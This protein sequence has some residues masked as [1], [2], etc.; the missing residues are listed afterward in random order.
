MKILRYAGRT[1][2]AL[3]YALAPLLA[4]GSVAGAVLAVC[5]S[6]GSASAL[7][8]ALSRCARG[9]VAR[10]RWLFVIH[11]W[12]RHLLGA[13]PALADEDDAVGSATLFGKPFFPLGLRDRVQRVAEGKRCGRGEDS[14]WRTARAF[15]RQ[16]RMRAQL[17]SPA[18]TVVALA[19]E[20]QFFSHPCFVGPNSP[21]ERCLFWSFVSMIERHCWSAAVDLVSFMPTLEA[22]WKNPAQLGLLLGL[23]KVGS[24]V[25][26]VAP[27]EL[28]GEEAVETLIIGASAECNCREELIWDVVGPNQVLVGTT[29][30][31]TDATLIRVGTALIVPS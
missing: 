22:W 14:A 10:G 17:G 27:G 30:S 20:T 6:S 12:I 8:E 9:F 7:V 31:D 25:Q 1:P 24:A 19:E 23:G 4:E 15:V 11:P 16:L 3:E 2:G 29:P 5:A 21:I 28:V 18:A 13:L 26:V